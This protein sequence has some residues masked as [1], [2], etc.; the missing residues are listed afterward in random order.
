[1]KFHCKIF[2]FWQVK[3]ELIKDLNNTLTAQYGEDDKK[4]VTDAF[5]LLQEKVQCLIL[6]F[7]LSKV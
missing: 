6:W 4:G 3:T 1:M 2:S 7:V 5:D